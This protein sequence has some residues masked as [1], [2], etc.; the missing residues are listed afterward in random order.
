MEELGAGFAL[1]S[2]DLEIRGAGELLGETQ[3]GL[4]DD[5][6]F[7]L[8]SEYLNEAVNVIREEGDGDDDGG[9]SAGGGNGT[10]DGDGDGD[11][12]G[13]RSV[14]VGDD[15]GGS[16]GRVTGDGGG[17]RSAAVGGG[18]DGSRRLV[19]VGVGFGG[20]E[21]LAASVDLHLPALFPADYL[22]NPHAR[23]MLYKRIA[24]AADRHELE[25]L[26]IETID[27][28]GLLPAAGKNLFRL[29][30]L[31]LQC[32]RLGIRKLSISEAG[33]NIEFT[34]H[35][36]VDPAVILNMIQTEPHRYRLAGPG[37]LAISDDF[38]DAEVRL[39]AVEALLDK[40][41]DGLG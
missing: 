31:R 17:G 37:T 8:Y 18:D 16:V 28:F 30:A 32:E 11:G 36:A 22:A 33:G 41:C 20:G 35:P 26:Q 9:L 24:G 6:G 25:E 1:A 10:S 27:R 15:T 12:D 5:V 4:I 3:S 13:G 23:L 7:S 38:A 39:V 19:S 29:T 14:A 34:E 2:H 40:W 21:R